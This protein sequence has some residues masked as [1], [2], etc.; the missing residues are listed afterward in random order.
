MKIFLSIIH[1]LS[2][3]YVVSIGLAIFNFNTLHIGSVYYFERT[4][5]FIQLF[6][7]NWFGFSI[8]GLSIIVGLIS[9]ILGAFLFGGSIKK[10]MIFILPICLFLSSLIINYDQKYMPH[11]TWG[12]IFDWFPFILYIIYLTLFITLF[13]EIIY[14]IGKKPFNL[15]TNVP[16]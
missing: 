16:S 10:W 12:N 4:L 15:T 2:G 5:P 1:F 11:G 6:Y 8:A 14:F 3:M 13:I 7:L 9:V